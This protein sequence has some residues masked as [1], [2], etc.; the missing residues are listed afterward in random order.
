MSNEKQ[1]YVL[2]PV[3]W[4]TGLDKDVKRIGEM[5]DKNGYNLAD[6]NI[7]YPLI[8]F[9]GFCKSV[10]AILTHNKRVVK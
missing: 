7:K 10:S 2:V 9:I 8:G 3:E 4:L 6:E 1:E 5:I